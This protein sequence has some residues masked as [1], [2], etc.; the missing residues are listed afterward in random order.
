VA[1]VAPLSPVSEP[2][3]LAMVLITDLD[4]DEGLSGTTVAYS[5]VGSGKH[6][7][8]GNSTRT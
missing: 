3:P 4:G 8:L 1:Q 5:C 6:D 2:S 7:L